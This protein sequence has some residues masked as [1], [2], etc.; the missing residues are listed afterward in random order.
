MVSGEPHVDRQFIPI[1][2]KDLSVEREGQRI[3][4][5]MMSYF[6]RRSHSAWPL[7]EDFS[8]PLYSLQ[9]LQMAI[10]GFM[11]TIKFLGRWI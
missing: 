11:S 3:S 7:P 6:F 8:L 10:I 4:L 9:I 5:L 1:L 2:V